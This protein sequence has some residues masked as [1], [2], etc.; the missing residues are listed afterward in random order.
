MT[1][2]SPRPVTLSDVAAVAGVS[3]STASK[4]LNGSTRISATTRARIEDAARRLD[5]RPNALA[6]SF[7][8]GRSHTVGVLAHR[9]TST[10]SHPV[11]IG[12]VLRLGARE[13][14]ALVYDGDRLDRNRVGESVR[15]LSARRIDGV[16]IVG[17]G[18][19]QRTRSLTADFHAPV[20]YAYTA[21]DDP[22]DLCF[23]PDNLDAGV[24]ATRHL[25]GLGRTRIA[26]IT[27]MYESIAVRRR[28][29]G[30][31]QVLASSG[32]TQVGPTRHGSWT[33]EWGARAIGDLL[34]EHPDV[35]AIFCGND[36]I[37][38]GVLGVLERR[39]IRVPDDIALVG[40][41][42]WE[43]VILDQGT[44]RLTS[45]DLHLSEIGGRSVDALLDGV[46]LTGPQYQAPSV[47]V[48]ATTGC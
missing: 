34:A 9:A 45:I 31:Q 24:L 30:F 35:E 32:L 17:D 22:D 46:M 33:E 14:A 47:V 1:S 2:G 36:H 8:S 27:A 13:R 25:V 11:L 44:R 43:G 6:Q 16:L 21:T 39:G 41:D 4:A 29:T 3:L 26:H 40:V 20:V 37:A 10:F 7:A 38:F 48:G 12:A 23:L 15:Q 42:N 5:F 19:E 18:H 28:E